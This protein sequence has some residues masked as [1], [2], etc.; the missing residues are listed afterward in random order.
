MARRTERDRVG[1]SENDRQK[2]PENLMA[3]SVEEVID[4]I[5]DLTVRDALGGDPATKARGKGG[6]AQAGRAR[7]R[8]LALRAPV[9]G[10]SANV[11]NRR[12][13]SASLLGQTWD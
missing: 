3:M 10:S 2:I 6:P 13:S 4:L 5:G 8:V 11:V 7:D 12:L 9:L 1:M